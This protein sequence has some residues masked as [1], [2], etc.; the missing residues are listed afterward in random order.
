MA[1]IAEIF[2]WPYQFLFM[3]LEPSVIFASLTLIPTS[4]S[5]HFHSLAP[6]DSAGP[7]WSPSPLQKSCDAESAWNTPQLRG[8]WYV[9]MAALSF[10]GVIEPMLLY[11]AR[12]KLRDTR[13]AE[14]VITTVLFAFIAFDVFH[15]GATLA[16][17]G[18]AAVLPGPQG[19]IYAMV[20]VWVPMAW[21]VL[22]MLWLVGVGRKSATNAVKRE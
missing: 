17:T 21:L 13:D 20:N 14:D 10:S 16:V 3:I 8:L 1:R 22:R 5:N 7:F 12:Y 9:F 6:T 11:L 4:P 15:A 2:P 18:A 19:H